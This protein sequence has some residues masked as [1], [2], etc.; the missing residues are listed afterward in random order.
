MFEIWLIYRQF[1]IAEAKRC[2]GPMKLVWTLLSLGIREYHPGSAHIDRKLAIIAAG[3]GIPWACLLHGY[4]GFVFGSVKAIAWWATALQ[5]LIFLSS[6]IVS[7]MAM[8]MLMY[9]FIMWRRGTP[10]DFPMFRKLVISLWIAFVL[11]WALE[12]LELVHVYYRHGHE[13]A[14]I[15][16]LLAGPLFDT[17]IIGQVFLTSLI[18]TV[19]M[20]FVVLSQARG[21]WLLYLGNL[22][23][24]LV[25]LQVLL[26][27][28]LMRYNVVIGG[29]LISKSGRGFL[30]YHLE[31]MG[32]E[33]L[34]M[35]LLIF[36]GPFV[37]Y[38][39]ISRFIPVFDTR[40]GHFAASDQ[41]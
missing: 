35:A 33:G 31:F 24:L 5:P 39:V 36:A 7:G 11:D 25:L 29:Q 40:I 32:K 18:P 3:V 20:G 15:G 37:A 9:S 19:L 16:P 12:M 1:F 26:Q 21:R 38:Y 8:I 4:V 22:C 13:W 2:T 30:D 28:L 41:T 34:L 23:G 17:Y 10:I 14:E 27:V 6:A